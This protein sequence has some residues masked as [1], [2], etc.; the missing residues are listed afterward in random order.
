MANATLVRT[1]ESVSAQTVPKFKSA[2]IFSGELWAL[3]SQPTLATGSDNPHVTQ[4]RP[5]STLVRVRVSPN[6]TVNPKRPGLGSNGTVAKWRV[7]GFDALYDRALRDNVADTA[8]TRAWRP[9][10][11]KKEVIHGRRGSPFCFSALWTASDTLLWPLVAVSWAGRFVLASPTPK[12]KKGAS[13][14]SEPSA[15]RSG[16]LLST[17]CLTHVRDAE[18]LVTAARTAKCVREKLDRRSKYSFESRT[19]WL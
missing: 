1:S 8:R 2:Q 11:K 3:S 15:S 17:V 12:F 14:V 13:L 16:T 10:R 9:S 18:P 19:Q 6:C 7:G 5:R 4:I